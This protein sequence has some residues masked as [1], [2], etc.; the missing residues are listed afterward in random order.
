MKL[1]PNK[2]L[3]VEE[4]LKDL[5]KYRP[6]RK[7]WTW[8]EKLPPK[9]EIG[10][11]E[12]YEVSKPLKNFVALPAAHYFKNIDPQPQEVITSEIASGRFE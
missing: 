8:R 7:G 2:K 3:N 10:D 11:F 6:K 5:D 4:I 12:Y 9:T 1:E